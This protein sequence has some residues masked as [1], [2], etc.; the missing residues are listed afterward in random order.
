MSEANAWSMAADLLVHPRNLLQEQQALQE[1]ALWALHFTPHVSLASSLQGWG[2]LAEVAP[3]LRLFEG[4]HNLQ[5]RL[6]GGIAELGLQACWATAP[7]AAGAWL[8]AQVAPL[9]GLGAEAAMQNAGALSMAQASA[10]FDGLPL[11]VL[12]S[13]QPHLATLTGIGCATLGQLRRLPR[14]GLAR[15]FGKSLLSEIDRAYGDEV[16]VHRWYE[17]PE[18]IDLK[19][20]LPARVDSTDALLF[21]ARRLLL[22]L[23]GWLTA[24][25]AAVAGIT[26]WLHHEPLHRRGEGNTARSTPVT[27]LLAAPS[28]DADHLGLLL[29]ERLGHV[30]LVAPVIEI[31]LVAD[32]IA[33]QA[34]PNT[35]LFPTPANDTENIGRLVERLQSRLG[36]EAVRRLATEADHR[37]EKSHA[38]PALLQRRAVPR[39]P[40]IS[41]P[42]GVDGTMNAIMRP[43][44]LLTQPLALLTRQH[45]PFYQSPLTLLAGPERIESGWWDDALALRDYFIAEND[46]HVLLWIFRLRPDVQEREADWFLHGFFA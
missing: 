15:R 16:Q 22:Q 3:S 9:C 38:S 10:V 36:P 26:L 4:L 1:A 25:H 42:A 13:A 20:E 19:L 8:M 30:V 39:R 32:Q 35:E 21:A 24:R 46:R 18:K 14:G 33:T 2:L 17:A 12:D 23:T 6:A 43:G 27:I 5:R 37:P 11:H 7:T 45:K 40:A 41:I 28:R 31:A 44:W 34:A 29:R